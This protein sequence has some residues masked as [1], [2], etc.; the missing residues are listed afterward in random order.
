MEI[1]IAKIKYKRAK[2]PYAFSAYASLALSIFQSFE[3]PPLLF[4]LYETAAMR[5]I[6]LY[7]KVKTIVTAFFLLATITSKAQVW[8]DTVAMID[9][10]FNKYPDNHPGAQ[11]AISRNGQLIY[12]SARG[13]ADIEHNTPI[14]KT[15]KIEAGSVSKQFTAACILLLEQ[16]GKL[17]LDDDIRKYVPQVPDYGNMITI[18]HLMNH[19][20]GIKDWGAIAELSGWPRGTKPYTNE[21]VLHIVSVQK[22]LNNKP[23][24]E[25]IYSNSGFNLLAIIIQRVSGNT[26]AEFSKK[27]LFGPAGMKNTE[28]RDDYKRN[29]PNRAIAYSPNTDGYRINMPNENAYGNGGLLTTAEDLLLWNEYYRN[30]KLGSPSL[31]AKQLETTPFN[32]GKKNKYAAGLI[33]DTLYG[34]P[35]IWHNGSTAAYRANLDLFPQQGLS[36]AWISNTSRADMSDVPAAIRNIL[37]K[38]PRPASRGTNTAATIDVKLFQPYTGAYRDI[39]TGE[40]LQL[41]I[42]DD[43]LYILPH[44]KIQPTSKTAALNGRTAL[45]FSAGALLSIIGKD[46]SFYTAAPLP[47]PNN[48]EMY[49][50]AYT[51]DE[52]ESTLNIILKESKLFVQF[53]RTRTLELTPVYKNGFSYPGGDAYFEVDDTGKVKGLFFSVARARNVAFK[54]I[55]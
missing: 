6:F 15:T 28:W 18:R 20:S 7:P 52:T 33:I 24:D 35:Y 36:I 31:L 4:N 10:V 54:K 1:N 39:K 23:N 11:L 45:V 51:S 8:A 16:Q 3:F 55:N 27:Y 13:L 19:A 38:H 12:S 21:D 32:N 29:V 37:I 34:L 48:L 14:D 25:Y 17:S 5:K 43:G 42:E 26:L 40:G 9:K 49:V 2:R 47:D 53:R 30:G 22:T 46:T 44:T 41:Y 50:S